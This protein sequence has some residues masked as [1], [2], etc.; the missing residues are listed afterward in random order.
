MAGMMG[1][2]PSAPLSKTP[3]LDKKIAAAQKKGDKKAIADAYAKRGTFRMYDDKAGA[4]VKYR[5]ALDDYRAAL[6][7]DPTNTEAAKSKKTIEDVYRSM[8][9]P[10]PGEEKSVVK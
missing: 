2:D 4:R 3:D 8:G 9:R 1:A 10:V 5:A 7:A 6:K